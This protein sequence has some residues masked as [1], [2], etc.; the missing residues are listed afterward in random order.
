MSMTCGAPSTPAR[1]RLEVIDRSGSVV[2]DYDLAASVLI[3][4][5]QQRVAR[6]EADRHPDLWLE[7]SITVADED[8]DVVVEL[9][10]VDVHNVAA[11]R[12][13]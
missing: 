11:F 12:R 7:S 13:R 3:E 9:P 10:S 6:P 4:I 8:G 2:G 5:R 1:V